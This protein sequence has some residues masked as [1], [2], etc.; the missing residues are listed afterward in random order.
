MKEVDVGVT[1][2]LEGKGA[3]DCE[4]I[5][6]SFRMVKPGELALERLEQENGRYRAVLTYKMTH[7]I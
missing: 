1:M 4:T 3:L 2:T 5:T 6:E 7:L